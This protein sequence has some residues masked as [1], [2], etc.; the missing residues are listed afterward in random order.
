MMLSRD[1]WETKSSAL[2]AYTMSPTVGPVMIGYLALKA[3]TFEWGSDFVFGLAGSDRMHGGGFVPGSEIQAGD[4][5]FCDGGYPFPDDLDQ[6]V[7][8]PH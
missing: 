3:M 4:Q 7:D 5:D 2:D 1:W 6:Y 8:C